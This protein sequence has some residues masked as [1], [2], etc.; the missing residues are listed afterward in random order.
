M[1]ARQLKRVMEDKILLLIQGPVYTNLNGRNAFD[2]LEAIHALPGRERFYVVYSLWRDTADDLRQRVAA[3][4]DCVILADKPLEAGAANRNYQAQGVYAG[5]IGIQYKNLRYCLK[6]RSDIVLSPKFVE[7]VLAMADSGSEKL[8]VTNLFT[9]LE[10]FHISD[11]LVFSTTENVRCL[12]MPAVVHYEDLYAPEVQFARVFMRA[13][14]LKYTMTQGDYFRF[15]RDWI[16]LVDFN[17]MRLQWLKEPALEIKARNHARLIME[18][19][20]CGPIL[21]RILTTR[22][23]QFLQKTRLPLGLIGSVMLLED[24]LCRLACFYLPF[25]RWEGYPVQQNTPEY[26]LPILEAAQ[27][28]TR[29]SERSVVADKV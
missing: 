11:M 7:R 8:L 20:D 27:G 12:F 28:Q 19:R 15:L 2:V 13:K 6:T 4:T 5:L 29:G 25:I 17:A 24:T 22:F 21:T 9:R 16:E 23:H 18:D 14:G 3:L 1:L 10:P 26:T